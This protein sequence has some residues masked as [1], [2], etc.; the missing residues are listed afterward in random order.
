MVFRHV[1]HDR[2]RA[3]E[4]RG[5]SVGFCVWQG[6]VDAARPA[7][8]HLTQPVLFLNGGRVAAQ[9]NGGNGHMFESM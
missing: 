3:R 9:D 5:L 6:R 8:S 4:K 2:E 1:I 7:D